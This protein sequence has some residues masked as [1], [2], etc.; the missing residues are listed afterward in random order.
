MWKN[1]KIDSNFNEIKCADF[2]PEIGEKT[3]LK[4]QLAFEPLQGSTVH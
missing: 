3:N 1:S 4:I 2:L